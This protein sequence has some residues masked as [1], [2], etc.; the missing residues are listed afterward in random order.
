MTELRLY[1]YAASS[2][3]LLQG[4]A[5][6]GPARPALR[7]RPDR[8][9]RGRDAQRRVPA[10]QPGAHQRRWL[11]IGGGACLPESAAILCYLAE[12]TPYLPDDRLA[13]AQVLRWLVFE[14][15]AVIPTIGG[16]R[17]RLMTGRLQADDPDARRRYDG[18]QQVLA[19]LDEQLRDRAFLLGEHYTIADIA[20]HAYIHVAGDAGLDLA[21]F[22]AVAAWLG[23]SRPS[24]TSS[25]TSS[26]IRPTRE[27][28]RAARST[29]DGRAP[30]ATMTAVG[31]HLWAF[32]GIAALVIIAPGPDT[33]VVTKNALLHG[34]RA[35][36]ATSLG[37]N[38]GLLIWTPW[39]RRSASPR[40][41]AS[42]RSPSPF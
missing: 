29:G 25:T 38:T 15:T 40:S 7:A 14:Q 41:C 13:R 23:G 8:H 17:F 19:L 1:D 6:A 2:Q 39:R 32:V 26:P 31:V 4:A 20:N 37:V 42:R 18:A 24:P 22:P 27:R 10:A 3:T 35:A 11:E 33:V 28:A 21:R 30:C 12:G 5:A 16:L 9:L 36:L 34:R